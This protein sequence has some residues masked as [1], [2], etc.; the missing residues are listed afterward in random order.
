MFVS[1]LSVRDLSQE[2]NVWNVI[3]AGLALLQRKCLALTMLSPG[4]HCRPPP[5]GRVAAPGSEAKFGRFSF[6]PSDASGDRP[7]LLLFS[8]R[9]RERER[10]REGVKA[11]K[12]G[13]ERERGER[14]CRFVCSC[15]LSLYRFEWERGLCV[16]VCVSLWEEDLK[17]M[18]LF[19]Y[20]CPPPLGSQRACWKQTSI[21]DTH[22]RTHTHTHTH[23]EREVVE[24]KE[25][26]NYTG[27]ILIKTE[28]QS[29]PL[30]FQTFTA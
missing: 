17:G 7:A 6:G 26:S 4:M 1:V 16:Y 30:R 15:E 22:A 13:K 14:R 9:E 21:H 19:F 20:T 29:C 27:R 11:S 10:E 3:V 2:I 12:R 25:V 23:I 18:Q 8:E 28:E 24:W 5:S